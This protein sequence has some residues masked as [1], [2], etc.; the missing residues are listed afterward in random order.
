M[1]PHIG[2]SPQAPTLA[3]R[4][5]WSVLHSKNKCCASLMSRASIVL[6]P[7]DNAL[8]SRLTPHLRIPL[9]PRERLVKTIKIL[10]KAGSKNRITQFSNFLIMKECKQKFPKIRETISNNKLRRIVIYI[11]RS[12]YSFGSHKRQNIAFF[13]SIKRL[14]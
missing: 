11:T 5:E 6:R 10:P 4:Q 2:A 1:P 3:V 7:L 9:C 12:K 14:S 8:A 13:N